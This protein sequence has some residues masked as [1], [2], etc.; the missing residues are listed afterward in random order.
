MQ[1]A[2]EAYNE[3]LSDADLAA[4]SIESLNEGQKRRNLFF[5]ANPLSVSLRPRLISSEAWAHTV[6]AAEAIYGALSTLETALLADPDLRSELDLEADE[7][8][9]AMADMPGGLSSPSSRLDS[10]VSAAVRHAQSNAAAP[11]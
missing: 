10:F 3:L 4:A 9:L 11:A 5:G 6:E 7:E 1:D 8:T 2:I